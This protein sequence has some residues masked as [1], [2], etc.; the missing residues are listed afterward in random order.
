T[1]MT[2]HLRLAC[3]LLACSVGMPA[4]AID[5]SRKPQPG[6]A[7]A[8]LPAD[9]AFRLVAVTRQPDAILVNWLI[10]PGYYLY[11]QRIAVEAVEAGVSLAAPIL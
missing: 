5:L 11:R 1:V 2:L 4:A 7:D 6:S 10:E 3:L 9:A 8:L